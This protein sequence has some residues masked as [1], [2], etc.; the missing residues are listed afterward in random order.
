[1]GSQYSIIKCK[2]R[3]ENNLIEIL[4]SNR[5]KIINKNITK[6]TIEFGRKLE[7]LDNSNI[8]III[9]KELLNYKNDFLNDTNNE[10]NIV[11]YLKELK[12][13]NIFE[14][15]KILLLYFNVL[16]CKNKT[17]F[18]NFNNYFS[19]I[20]KFELLID[21]LYQLKDSD[22]IRNDINCGELIDR[23]ILFEKGLLLNTT[24]NGK[25]LSISFNQ[26]RNEFDETS[27]TLLREKINSKVTLENKRSIFSESY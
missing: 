16:S 6:N 12:K 7:N 10:K 21:E 5:K 1:M 15:E 9:E 23:Y 27:K 3:N 8:N 4:I 13:Y 26:N 25:K 2:K 24:K 17:Y 19:Y 20:D 22:D 18:T 11:K 14:Y